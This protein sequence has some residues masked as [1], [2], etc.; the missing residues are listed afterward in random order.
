MEVGTGPIFLEELSC[1]GSEITLLEC[2]Q[3]V[4][5]IRAHSC[6]HSS[7]VGLSCEGSY[8]R[9]CFTSSMLHEHSLQI[10][11]SVLL[12]WQT[13]RRCATIRLVAIPVSVKMATSST[14]TNTLAT[15]DT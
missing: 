13:A 7:D 9:C 15:V 14:L 4:G 3:K 1:D 5:P 6:P 10:S 12:A 2:A 11:M 8:C